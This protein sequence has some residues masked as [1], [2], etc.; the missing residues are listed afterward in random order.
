[1][2]RSP[3]VHSRKY[4]PSKSSIWLNCPL[5]TVFNDGTNQ[6]TSPQAEFG[7]QCHELGAALV[8]KSLGLVDYDSEVKPIDELIKELDMYSDEMQDIADGY[9]DYIVNTIEYEKKRSETEPFVVI[10]QLLDMDFDEDARGTLDCGIIS[11]V[12]G[13]TLTVIDLK[14]GRSPVYAFDH[15]AGTFNTQ[16]AIYAL[17]FYKA[18][19]DL[20]P[21]KHIRLAIYQPVINNTNDYEISIDDLLKFESEVLIPAVLST[22]VETPHGNPGKHCRYC[23]GRETCAVR[24]NAMMETF[25]NSNKSIAQLTDS[26]IES[27]LP[28]LD[29]MIQF[30]EDIKSY[31]LKKAKRGYKWPDYKLVHARVSRKIT[32][33][34]GLIKACEEVGINPYTAQKVAGI[35][36]LTKRIGKDKVTSIIGPYITMQTGSM[37][38]VPNT[39]PREEVITI[40]KGE[41]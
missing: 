40:E 8:S 21:V 37:I 15:E 32:D 19:K 10:E 14:T 35:T 3:T 16:L 24:A 13:G 6:E 38:L 26:D 20:Y 17:Y 30:A 23:S 31:A 33:E 28:K 2:S 11:G 12:D 41:K 36:E 29:E 18:Y 34:P 9:A 5:S 27:L 7:T 22:R 25:S 4:S 1:M 39:D